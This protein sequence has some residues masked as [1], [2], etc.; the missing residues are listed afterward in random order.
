M[1]W[2]RK[3]NLPAVVDGEASGVHEDASIFET[4]LLALQNHSTKT[5]NPI[6]EHFFLMLRCCFVFPVQVHR[7][8]GW[9]EGEMVLCSKTAVP[10]RNHLGSLLRSRL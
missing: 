5:V 3:K 1:W 10:S 7:A 8:Q 2:T 9:Q 6:P 4:P